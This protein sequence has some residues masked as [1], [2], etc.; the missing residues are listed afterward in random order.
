V[1]ALP[2]QTP[3]FPVRMVPAETALVTVEAP[4]TAKFCA[5]PNGGAVAPTRFSTSQSKEAGRPRTNRRRYAF[6]NPFRVTPFR[7]FGCFRPERLG[8]PHKEPSLTP[9]RLLLELELLIETL[10]IMH[11]FS[12]QIKRNLR[13]ENLKKYRTV[14]F[15]HAAKGQ[16][17][18]IIGLQRGHWSEAKAEH[19]TVQRKMGVVR[20]SGQ[21]V[22]RRHAGDGVGLH[23]HRLFHRLQDLVERE[24]R[25]RRGVVGYPVGN[26]ELPAMHQTAARV[27]DIGHIAV[28]LIYIGFDQWF[29]QPAITLVGSSRSTGKRRCSTFAWAPPRG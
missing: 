18:V 3:R 5:V 6:H 19:A 16:S 13:V 23:F 15:L 26:H 17:A 12:T 25:E 11:H 9:S 1:T 4:R 28:P 2:G 29:R 8:N 24:R 21:P 20:G 22:S 10:C 7:L 14:V 27:N